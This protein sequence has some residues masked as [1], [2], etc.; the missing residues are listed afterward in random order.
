M[1]CDSE[2]NFLLEQCSAHDTITVRKHAHKASLPY[3]VTAQP[4]VLI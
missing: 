1:A 4:D 3:E 2:S